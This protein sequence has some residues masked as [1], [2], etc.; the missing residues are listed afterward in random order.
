MPTLSIT[1]RQPG[2]R[3]RVVIVVVIYVSV[4]RLLPHEAAPVVL[5]SV[6]GRLLAIEP[7]KALPMAPIPECG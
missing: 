7:A 6:L 3:V 4:L 2:R 5:G 1:W